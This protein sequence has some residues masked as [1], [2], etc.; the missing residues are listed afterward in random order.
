MRGKAPRLPPNPLAR[1]LRGAATMLL[2]AVVRDI[3]D[4]SSPVPSSRSRSKRWP[5][6]TTWSLGRPRPGGRGL[7]LTAVLE[8]RH[9][10]AIVLLGDMQDQPQLLADLH[11][12][13][14]PV[15]ALW[16]GSSLRE[17]PA[18]DVDNDAGVLAGLEHLV[19]LGHRRIAF[20]SGRR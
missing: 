4:R 10:D 3:T 9:C 16:Q 11:D 6:A 17:L 5:A 18:V 13:F 2:G 8:T 15:V 7:A 19:G 12:S 1:G 14:V 20:V